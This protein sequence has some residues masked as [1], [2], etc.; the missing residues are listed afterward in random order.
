MY[1]KIYSRGSRPGILY[2]L[3]KVHKPIIDNCPK[4]RPILYAIGTPTFKLVKFLVPILSPLTVNEFSVHDSFPFANEVSS[5]CPDHY[6]PLDEVID[7][8]L[9]DLFSDNDTIHNLD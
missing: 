7:I 1:D 4:F 9:N 5:F 8:C 2:G 3:P 6:T